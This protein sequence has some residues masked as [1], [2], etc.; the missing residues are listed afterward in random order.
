MLMPMVELGGLEM[1]PS[2]ANHGAGQAVGQLL[3]QDARQHGSN[4]RPQFVVEHLEPDV[5][6]GTDNLQAL[7]VAGKRDLA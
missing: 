4:A 2:A 3:C 1:A 5:L 7:Q 6:G